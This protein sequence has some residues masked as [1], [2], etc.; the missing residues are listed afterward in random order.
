MA[1]KSWATDEQQAWLQPWVP[2][3]L[4]KQAEKKL[5]VFWNTLYPQWFLKF[6]EHGVLGLPLPTDPEAREL[7]D[8]EVLTVGAAIQSRKCINTWFR[9]QRKKISNGNAVASARVD[10]MVDVL[11]DMKEKPRKRVHQAVEFFAKRNHELIRKALTTEGYDNLPE[12]ED[13]VDD[14]TDESDG[15]E[16]ARTKSLKSARMR[17]R[18]RVV[19]AL[20]KQASEEER[21]SVLREIEQEKEKMAADARAEEEGGIDGLE[22]FLSKVLGAVYKGSG[23]VGITLVGGPNPRMGGDLSMKIVCHGTTPAGN[24]FEDSCIDFDKNVIE[25]F[26]GFLQQVY[27]PEECRAVALETR[28]PETND[29]SRPAIVIQAPVP[30]PLPAVLAK[31]SKAKPKRSSNKS[32]VK[33]PADT[34]PGQ[35]PATVAIPS[36][37]SLD[38]VQV[39]SSSIPPAPRSTEAEATPTVNIENLPSVSG[40]EGD[41]DFQN[42]EDSGHDLSSESTPPRL[43]PFGLA[44]YAPQHSGIGASPKPVGKQTAVA[45]ALSALIVPAATITTHI[46]AVPAP[47]NMPIPA[48]SPTIPAIS[49]PMLAAVPAPITSPTADIVPVPITVTIPVASTTIPTISTPI[50]A[51]MPVAPASR[52]LARPI[53]EP[54]AITKIH[55]VVKKATATSNKATAKIGRGKVVEK[56]VAAREA[57]DVRKK[58]GRPSKA[59]KA[60]AQAALADVTNDPDTPPAPIYTISNN[61]R[62]AAQRAAKEAMAEEQKAADDARVAQR[63]KG[64]EPGPVEGTVILLRNRK[65]RVHADG[66]LP[67]RV[68][69]GTRAPR[70]DQS[71]RVLL[72]RAQSEKRKATAAPSSSKEPA[73]K[74]S[75]K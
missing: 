65:P 48:V 72:A 11:F 35:T 57:Q 8:T 28:T 60:A 34:T 56:E 22:T 23:W 27:T 2:D 39:H 46:A 37:A 21:A 38:S 52:P 73:K 33:N 9:Y 47:I 14:W 31:K 13:E 54:E 29:P 51:T 70:L 3:F 12:R 68:V 61:N 20:W 41:E 4:R 62:A 49:T 50:M 71:E 44:H 59:D 45:R 6:P 30:S 24:D 58:R 42:L 1:P 25:A 40:S 55:D 26:E 19:S 17:M 69:K 16:A 64:W 75:K 67:Q 66:S 74:K 15:S 43:D 7:T 32:P 63:A 53:E 36:L 5:H 18:T 10:A